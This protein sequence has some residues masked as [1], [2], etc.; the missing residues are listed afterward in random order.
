MASV[1][2]HTLRDLRTWRIRIFVVTWLAYVGYYFTRKHLPVVQPLF[3]EEYGWSMFDL[4]VIAA[5]F[6]LTY[7]V[8]QLV[9]GAVGDRFGARRL[10]LVGMI[11]TLAMSLFSGLAT[12]VSAF[13]VIWLVN[14]FA[15]ATGWPA[16]VA[17]MARW[18]PRKTRGRVM[19]WWTTN[20]MVGDTLATWL[21]AASIAAA[22]TALTAIRWG[23]WIPALAFCVVI[24]VVWKWHREA[25]EDVGIYEVPDTNGPNGRAVH[26]RDLA[27]VVKVPGLWVAAVITGALKFAMY[28]FFFWTVTYLVDA[29]GYSDAAAGYLAALLP[30]GGA[31]GAICAGWTSDRLFTGRRI[32]VAVILLFVLAVVT[33][34]IPYTSS[35]P[36]VLAAL[37]LVAG[38]AIYG[39]ESLLAGAGAIEYA[40][41][42]AM[43]TAVG[44]VNAIGSLAGIPA[45]LAT[46]AIAES[47]GWEAVFWMVAA[48][49][50]ITMFGALPLWNSRGK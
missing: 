19:G 28:V 48:L 15:Q 17:T 5:A 11:A 38:F 49:A 13:I 25:P 22:P 34:A 23:F 30:L 20:Y 3:L 45:G 12:T 26:W 39:P 36:Y 44:F 7:A 33:V 42:G 50:V 43:G 16:T 35:D 47:F 2:L 24:F 21:A 40:P 6:Q 18:F 4:G 29:R 9:M 10:L 14:G 41:A 31:A 37:F 27:A 46:A 8:G 1:S 32:P